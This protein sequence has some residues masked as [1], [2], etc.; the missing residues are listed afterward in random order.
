[1]NRHLAVKVVRSILKHLNIVK[2]QCFVF[3]VQLSAPEA[4]KP[5]DGSVARK[6]VMWPLQLYLRE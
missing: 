5:P 1:M 2:H 4:P 3:L 6:V